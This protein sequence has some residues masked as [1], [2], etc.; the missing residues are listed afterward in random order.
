MKKLFL[1]LSLLASSICATENTQKEIKYVDQNT[2]MVELYRQLTDFCRNY[3]N[4]KAILIAIPL[5]LIMTTGE[6]PDAI[7][8]RITAIAQSIAKQ[9]LTDFDND[10]AIELMAQIVP[11]MEIIDSRIATS[12]KELQKLGV[13]LIAMSPFPPEHADAMIT[14]MKKLGLDFSAPTLYKK[15]LPVDDQDGNRV[16]LVKKGIIFLNDY[17]Q[18]IP[19]LETLIGNASVEIEQFLFAAPMNMQADNDDL[20]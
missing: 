17:F 8:D 19:V 6:L 16:A 10:A 13:R 7:Q 14:Q 12:I 15:E 5:D 9:E 3:E 11:Y 18:S 20:D 1:S 2:F 4:P